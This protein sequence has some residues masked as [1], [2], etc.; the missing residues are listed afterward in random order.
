LQT[1]DFNNIFL[2]AIDH[3]LS[4]LG[5]SSKTSIYFHLEKTYGVKK[6]DI[7]RKPEEFVVAVEKLFGPGSK[8]IVNLISKG[9][10]QKA[11]LKI[12]R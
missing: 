7:P 5:E 9:L 12:E 11:G 3:S 2:D 8:F 10:C 1:P 4:V 6:Q